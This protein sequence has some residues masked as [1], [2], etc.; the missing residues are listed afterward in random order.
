MAGFKWFQA[1]SVW[2][3]VVSTGFRSLLFLVSTICNL[4]TYTTFGAATAESK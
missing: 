2:F 4:T 1:I 3:Q